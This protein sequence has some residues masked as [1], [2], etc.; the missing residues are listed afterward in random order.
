LSRHFGHSLSPARSDNH[1]PDERN[2]GN[3]YF[4]AT[5]GVVFAD[6][7]VLAVGPAAADVAR[8]FDRYWASASSYPARQIR[9]PA[10]SDRL[11][12]LDQR[13]SKLQRDP[14]AAAYVDA[15]RETPDVRE[16]LVSG[17]L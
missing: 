16:L 11:D 17:P 7:D 14:A 4:G 2:I 6:L 1:S 10:A 15:I 3:E 9:S 12:A 13:A 5:D 8:D